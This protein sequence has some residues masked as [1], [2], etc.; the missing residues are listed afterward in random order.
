MEPLTT[1]EDISSIAKWLPTQ[2]KRWQQPKTV[3]RPPDSAREG[4]ALE[5]GVKVG[6]GEEQ[7][8]GRLREAGYHTEMGH[9]RLYP[10][11]K[12]P[13]SLAPATEMVQVQEGPL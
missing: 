6:R 4:K 2:S 7:G 13:L 1:A 9:A 12:L 10:I 11:F 8:V 5:G 3:T